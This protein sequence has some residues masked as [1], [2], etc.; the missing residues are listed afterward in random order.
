MDLFFR[1]RITSK[2]SPKKSQFCPEVP[3]RNDRESFL[4]IHPIESFP[5]ATTGGQQPL[6]RCALQ[7]RGELEVKVAAMIGVDGW[8]VLGRLGSHDDQ[9]VQRLCQAFADG[10]L[11]IREI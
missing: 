8:E 5:T 2:M 1:M 6:K 9:V 4:V 3:D 7:Q 10:L 11:G